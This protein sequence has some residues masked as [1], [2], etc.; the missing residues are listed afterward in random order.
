M[1]RSEK[2]D[3]DVTE[4]ETG[5]DYIIISWSGNIGFGEYTL[6]KVKDKW[7]GDSECMDQ[8]ED[9]DFLRYLLSKVADQITC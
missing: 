9:K 5:K 3:V 6:Y 1:A 8:G 7:F 4:I 2:W